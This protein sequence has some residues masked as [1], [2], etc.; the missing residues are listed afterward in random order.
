MRQII[1]GSVNVL[2]RS[3]YLLRDSVLG[4]I[5]VNIRRDGGEVRGMGRWGS[6][7]ERWR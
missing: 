3:V 4:D 1:V 2:F 7:G 6:G 5:S